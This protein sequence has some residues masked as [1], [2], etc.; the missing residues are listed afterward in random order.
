MLFA[1]DTYPPQ[2]N[3]VSV[4]SAL[5]VEGLSKRGWECAVI[6]PRYPASRDPAVFA[7]DEDGTQRVAN[8][9]LTTIPSAPLPVYPDIRLSLPSPW[10]V[11]RAIA[12][13]APDLEAGCAAVARKAKPGDVIV[14]LGAG[15]VGRA[16]ERILRILEGASAGA[17]AGGNA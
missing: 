12:E 9:T 17:S 3:G 5:S 16:G 13:F 1:T 2:V 15:D 10:R 8:E 4:V 14:T 6:A 11:Q 7:L